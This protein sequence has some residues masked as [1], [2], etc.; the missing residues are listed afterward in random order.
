MSGSAGRAADERF[1]RRALALAERGLGTTNPNPAVGCVIV[2]GGRVVGEGF[3][4]RAGGPHA[5]PL[6]LS[7]AGARARGATAYIT[8]EPCAPNDAKRTP[9]CAPRLFEAGITRVV[10][11][12]PDRNPGV[13]G[14]GLSGLRAAGLSVEGP[15]LAEECAR[16]TQHFNRAMEAGRPWITLKAGMTLDGRVATASGQSKWITSPE[17]RAAARALRGLFDGLLVGIG[18]VLADDPMLLPAPRTARPF[19]RIVLDSNLR[20]PLDSVLVRTAH[21]H[22]V[23]ALCRKAD[24][25]RRDALESRGVTVVEVLAPG[26]RVRLGP[27]LA[28]LR[29]MSL[30]SLMVE[31]G[32][33]VMGSFVREKLFDEFVAFRAPT[34]LGGRRSRGAIGGDDPVSI[35]EAVRLQPAR[36]G[37]NATLRYGL[38]QGSVPGVEIYEVEAGPRARAKE[39]SHVHRHR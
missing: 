15:V 31:G 2:R 23:I 29:E 3:H 33:E 12:A 5:E 16:L 26:R 39:G 11:G 24:P 35:G 9:A 14:R 21:R 10:Y 30:S 7:A 17:Q 1:M 28:V 19:F 20:L 22:P 8:L 4:E 38:P 37:T 34:L 36:V 25:S 6:A 32:P 18:T 27:A 13:R